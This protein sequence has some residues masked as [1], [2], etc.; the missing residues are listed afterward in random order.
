MADG[1]T[2]AQFQLYLIRDQRCWHCGTTDDTLVPQHRIGRGMG[3]KKKK[4]EQP[5]NVLVLCSWAN[6]ELESSAAFAETGR[7]NGW[8]LS[9]WQDP[10]TEPA[11]D[12]FTGRWFTLDNDYRRT[13]T[14]R[15]G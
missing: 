1:V 7:R 3:G 13:E 6:G 10:E 9:S 14:R 5:S 2:P 11:F 15:A 4:A 12:V 8:K